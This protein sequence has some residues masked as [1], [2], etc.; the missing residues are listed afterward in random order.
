MRSVRPSAESA[1]ILALPR[2]PADAAPPEG[3]FERWR[4]TPSGRGNFDL[5]PKQAQTLYELAEYGGAMG[6]LALGEGK[7]GIALLAGSVLGAERTVLLVAASVYA[8]VTEVDYPAWAEHWVLPPLRTDRGPG[9]GLWIIKYTD[10]SSKDPKKH[11]ALEEIA[12][13]LVVSDESHTLARANIRRKRYRRYVNRAAPKV[14]NLSGTFMD[15]SIK[16][17]APLAADALGAGSPYPRTYADLDAWSWAL[18]DLPANSGLGV[19]GAFGK[20]LDEARDG[21]CRWVSETPGFVVSNGESCGAALRFG[22]RRLTI[23]GNVNQALDDLRRF[24]VRPDGFELVSPLEFHRAAR[25]LAL[26]FYLRWTEK[27]PDEWLE[28][29]AAWASELSAFLKRSNRP[30]LDS[31]ALVTEA[32]ATGKL[33]LRSYEKWAAVEK[34]FKPAGE[35]V[36]LD[37]FAARDAALWATEPGKPGIVWSEHPSFGERVAELAGVPWYGGGD[38]ASSEILKEPGTRSMVA[39]VSSHFFGKNLQRFSRALITTP[40]GSAR[41]AGQTIGRIHRRGQK[42]DVVHVDFY[43]HTPEYQSAMAAAR[44]NAEVN[45]RLTKER[46]KL[47][48][49]RWAS[50]APLP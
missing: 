22:V 20:T 48:V 36:W 35:V 34:A 41:R 16:D 12:A 24:W 15:R 50:P 28:A 37:E 5:M 49:G 17:P 27:A 2:R 23:P 21:F 4:R 31:P 14:L 47:V 33:G 38:R 10:L 39:S 3:Y 32:A 1:R 7:T 6:S 44:R 25:T 40:P 45:Q 9:P 26:G 42:A 18:D 19:L 8:Q 30:G 29:R 46:Q 11:N 43:L 13:T